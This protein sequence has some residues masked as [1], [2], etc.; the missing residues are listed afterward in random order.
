[1]EH[2]L[3]FDVALPTAATAKGEGEE[4]ADPWTN[5]APARAVVGVVV[6]IAET[7]FAYCI[8]FFVSVRR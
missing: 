5:H 3:V 1:M 7:V 8:Q 4:A 6:R 2:D